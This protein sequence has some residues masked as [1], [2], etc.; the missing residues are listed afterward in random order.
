MTTTNLTALVLHFRDHAATLQCLSSLMTD[1]FV[2][3]IVIDNSED[4][5]RSLEAL[6][7]ACSARLS[8]FNILFHHNQTNTGFA[9]GANIGIAMARDLGFSRVLLINSDATLEAGSLNDM[10]ALGRECAIT[11]PRVRANHD[12][13]PVSPLN[14]YHRPTGLVLRTARPGAFPYPTGCC[15]LLNLELLPDTPLFDEDFFFYGEDVELAA[16]LASSGKIMQECHSA[17]VTHIGSGSSRNGSF[18][19]EYH[20]NRSHLLLAGK[21]APD[22]FRKTGY[23]L[24][25][26]VILP[27]RATLRSWRHKSLAPWSALLQAL[28]DTTFGSRR[29]H[30]PPPVNGHPTFAVPPEGR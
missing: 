28:L 2:H 17:T 1:G 7:S 25:R 18:F 16:R 20:V 13:P 19:Y 9:R 23:L 21:L 11:Y 26:L 12:A 14:H 6:Q 5:G 24:A 27:L 8:G 10:Q 3:A 15:L 29:S 4:A 30:T 22:S